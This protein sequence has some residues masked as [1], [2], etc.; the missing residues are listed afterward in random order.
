MILFV[1]F[2]ALALV[3]LLCAGRVPVGTAL[4]VVA[5]GGMWLVADWEF[6]WGTITVLPFAVASNYTFVV[7]PMFVMMGAIAA[8]GG[9][10]TRLYNAAHTWTAGQRGGLL[11][12][13]IVASALFSTLSGS[14]IVNAA[15]FTRVALPEMVRFGY[16]KATSAAAIACAGT[17]AALVP[18]SLALV[19]YGI[20]T[21]TPIGPLMIAGIVPALVTV[22]A[23][24]VLVPIL[25]RIK[26][27]VAP[28]V[29]TGRLRLG[30]KLFSLISI[31][32]IALLVLTVLGGLY[33]GAMPPSAA[34]AVGAV[35]AL[36]ITIAMRQT[37]FD[38]I[39]S[40][41]RET[42]IMTSVL[43]F[44]IIAGMLFSRFLIVSGFIEE[45]NAMLIA[46]EVG[47]VMFMASIIVMYLLLGMFIDPLSMSVVTLPVVFP[48]IVGLGINPIWFAIVF[49]KL[50]EI[51]AITP[52]LGMNL[53]AV[54][55]ASP[56]P[57]SV[58]QIYKGVAPFLVLE[59]LVLGVILVFP[60]IATW[61]PATIG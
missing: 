32:P 20:L 6:M 17:L 29:D 49:V 7:V 1:G 51:A 42:A 34:G 24:L 12:T 3:I 59:I 39:W 54:A 27:S 43:F 16:D 15:V 47:P 38:E 61:L 4:G 19:I 53:F 9:L 21:N 44:I 41:L 25:V 33:S 26:G 8:Q 55:A 48:V 60:G 35:G 13:T 10:I 5:I 57:I 45:L 28:P 40:A 11:S 37:G 31:W 46:A 30:A 2:A 18:P 14:T 50:V 36:V 52:P 22:I 56:E 58:P 23:Y